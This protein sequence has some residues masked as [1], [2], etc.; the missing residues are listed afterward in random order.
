MNHHTLTIVALAAILTCA[1]CENKGSGGD[2]APKA[3]AATPTPAMTTATPTPAPSASGPSTAT[4]PKVEIQI[5]SVGNEMK[6]DKTALTVPAGA[7]VH[8][9]LKNNGTMD[10]MSHNW[11]L[12][13][14]GTEALVALDGLNKAPDAGFVVPGADVYTYTPLAPPGKTVE[15]TF[16][17]PAAGKYPYIC[18]FPGHYVLMKGVLTVTP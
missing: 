8:L 3:T 7:E 9:V 12:V 18:T 16:T 6:F 14:T 17:A 13:K 2:E 15:V 10:T 1:S 4:A 5:A 11:V